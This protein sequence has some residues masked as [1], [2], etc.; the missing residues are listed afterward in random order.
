MA[1]DDGSNNMI[2]GSQVA[3]LGPCGN[4]GVA[5][6]QEFQ[7]S[8]CLLRVVETSTDKIRERRTPIQTKPPRHI[9]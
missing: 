7:V 8:G 9:K 5:R 3:A 2:S 1:V 4:F 6:I